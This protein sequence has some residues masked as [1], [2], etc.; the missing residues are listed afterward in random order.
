MFRLKAKRPEKYRERYE[1]KMS[2]AKSDAEIQRLLDKRGG[3]AIQ[4]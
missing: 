1:V 3:N 2:D 4:S